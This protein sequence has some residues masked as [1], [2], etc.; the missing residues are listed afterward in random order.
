MNNALS[1]DSKFTQYY[2]Q[3]VL[4]VLTCS[5]L[6][7]LQH[8]G[9]ELCHVAS[10]LGISGVGHHKEGQT[11]PQSR[12]LEGRLGGGDITVQG[13][14]GGVVHLGKGSGVQTGSLVHAVTCV[15]RLY[16]VF[17]HENAYI[18]VGNHK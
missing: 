9:L 10:S 3:R 15:V 18:L 4:W 17:E 14:G 5:L 13:P 1:L 16:A 11:R 6:G 7:H 2:R 8:K 12:H